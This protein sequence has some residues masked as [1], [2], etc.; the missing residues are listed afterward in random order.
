MCDIKTY[1]CVLSHLYSFYKCVLG[2]KLLAYHSSFLF[3]EDYNSS[4]T[5]SWL[6]S[7]GSLDKDEDSGFVNNAL[8]QNSIYITIIAKTFCSR[9]PTMNTR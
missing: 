6:E 8:L 7:N 4:K 9:R 3:K 5:D 1:L 2:I